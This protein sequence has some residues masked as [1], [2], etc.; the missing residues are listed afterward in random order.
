MFAGDKKH[1]C[2]ICD[3]SFTKAWSLKQHLALHEKNPQ[4]L[5]CHICDFMASNKSR[6]QTHLAAHEDSHSS[7]NALDEANFTFMETVSED[8]DADNYNLEEIQTTY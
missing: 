5:Q 4:V 3:A 7:Q 8:A 1:M 2:T 6:L